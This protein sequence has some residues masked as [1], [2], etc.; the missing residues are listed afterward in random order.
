VDELG[1]LERAIEIAAKLAGIKG[2]PK[3]IYPSASSLGGL[4]DWP[5]E[6]LRHLRFESSI[7]WPREATLAPW[8]IG[9]ILGQMKSKSC[10]FCTAPA[11]KK[12]RENYILGRSKHAFAILNR[13]PYN[14][15]H[16]LIVPYQHTAN[17]ADLSDE[18]LL[19]IHRCIRD[20][21][22]ILNEVVSRRD[23]TSDEFGGGGRCRH[24][25]SSALPHRP[26]WTGDTNFMPVF[27]E[28]R[29]LPESLDETY[30]R[31]APSF[32]KRWP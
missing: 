29:I 23:I 22:T 24:P 1:G 20:S 4:S 30:M 8:R 6:K 31:L 21:I 19:D 9:F 5:R 7:V 17:L 10:V 27:G 25:R 11:E 14:T 15:S 26:R 13:Y 3:P 12:D 32:A 28:T 18:A 2:E 16:I